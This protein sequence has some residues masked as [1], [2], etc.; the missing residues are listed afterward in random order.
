MTP[1]N[2]EQAVW[3]ACYGARLSRRMQ[4]LKGADKFARRTV[5]NYEEYDWLYGE[6]LAFNSMFD[7]HDE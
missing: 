5:E 6:W 7:E 2:L 1:F 4:K 3:V